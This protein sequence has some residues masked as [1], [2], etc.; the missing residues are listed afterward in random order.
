MQPVN[1]N[2]D[3]LFRRAAENY[4]LK[5]EGA[6]WN[7]V[8]ERLQEVKSISKGNDNKLYLWLLL[9]VLPLSF[10]FHNI[11]RNGQYAAKNHPV[12]APYT[13]SKVEF[14]KDESYTGRNEEYMD[15]K[16]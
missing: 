11:S 9:L 4:P 8:L 5:P 6:D 10:L 15:V 12:H 7:K 13:V 16:N 2:M 1:N 3:D 14:S